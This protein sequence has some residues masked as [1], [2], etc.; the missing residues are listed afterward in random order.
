MTLELRHGLNLSVEAAVIEHLRWDVNNVPSTTREI[1]D[2]VGRSA[3]AVR[4]VLRKMI[5]GGHAAR[6]HRNRY[7]LVHAPGTW[8][9]S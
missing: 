4:R 7:M 3:S 1:A 9:E 8:I 6:V 5:A 2:G